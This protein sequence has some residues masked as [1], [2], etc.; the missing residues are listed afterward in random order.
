MSSSSS[1]TDAVKSRFSTQSLP[2]CFVYRGGSSHLRSRIWLLTKLADEGSDVPAKVRVPFRLPEVATSFQT[3]QPIPS[4]PNQ[5]HREDR[6]ARA[7]RHSKSGDDRVQDPE[8]WRTRRNQLGATLL[9]V[10]VLP[11]TL[12]WYVQMESTRLRARTAEFKNAGITQQTRIVRQ[13]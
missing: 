4:V 9:V 10:E 13:L 5:A 1:I 11:S 8:G 12:I 3:S 2:S 6:L 7:V